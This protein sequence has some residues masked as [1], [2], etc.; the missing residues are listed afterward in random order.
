MAAPADAAP[1]QARH[2]DMRLGWVG[3]VVAGL[4]FLAALLA[5]SVLGLTWSVLLG[6]DQAEA[7]RDLGVTVVSS[8]G[9]WVGFLYLPV[10]WA[11]NREDPGRLLGL[12]GRWI[13]LPL[14]LAVGLASSVSTGLASV[15]LLSA[16]E[17]KVLEAKA[18]ETIDRAHGPAAVVLLVVVLCVVTPIAE[19]VFFRGLLFRSLHRITHLVVAVFIAGLVFG[20]V[21]YDPSPVPPSVVVAQLG[22]LAL[23]GMVLCVLTHRTGRLGAGIVAHAAFNAVTVVT[24]LVQR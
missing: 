15:L 5:A 22:L 12:T 16:S 9:L 11:R 17:E 8:V 13:D 1:D 10:L 3:L 19:E 6:L 24:L 2:A 4:C 14:G 23:F 21:H 18:E 7:K 20:L